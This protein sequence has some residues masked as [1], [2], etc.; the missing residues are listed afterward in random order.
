MSEAKESGTSGEDWDLVI[1]PNSGWL[2]LN[3]KEVWRY[4]DLLTLLI[5]RDFITQYKQTILGP[6]WY[7][8]QPVLTTLMFLLLFS[9]V[10]RIPTEGM[11]PTVFY[12]SGLTLWTYF[13]VTLTTISTT[14]VS[15][16]SIFGKVYFPRLV[17]PLSVMVSNLMR[18]LIQFGL[19]LAFMTWHHFYGFPVVM[20]WTWLLIPF[21]LLVT[22]ALSLGLGILVASL[23]TKY[24]DLTVLMSFLVQL[25]MY[26][27]PI[28]YP[29]SFLKDMSLGSVL[30]W[31]P[32]TALVECYRYCLFGVGSFT[33]GGLLYSF[34]F[35][36][37]VMLCG[38]VAFSRVE[39]SFMDTV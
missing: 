4:R 34:A 18:F 6:L 2:Q 27:T 35:C 15:N 26:A 24:R 17:M 14:F 16:A 5:K 8:I 32:L 38:L 12:M 3:L 20:R 11:H 29:F 10:A 30:A 28:A 9:R 7:L 19:L 31:N 13:S 37:V 33:S 25:L 39:K 21:L 36:L 22:G 1:S 23:T